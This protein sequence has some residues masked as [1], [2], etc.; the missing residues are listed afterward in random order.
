LGRKLGVQHT[1]VA[2]AWRDARLQPHRPERYMRSTDPGFETRAAD[3]IG[4][5]LDPRTTPS[6]SAST[7]RQPSKG[8]IGSIPCSRCRTDERN[9]TGSSRLG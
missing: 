7:K 3:V 9:V 2:R 4:L 8:T 1:I 5:Y 6:C